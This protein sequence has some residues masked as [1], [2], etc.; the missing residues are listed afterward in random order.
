M[1]RKA[2]PVV[3]AALVVAILAAAM[4]LLHFGAY[5]LYIVHTG[6]MGNTI[7]SRSAV[8]VH[9]GQYHVGQVVSFTL[10]GETVTHRLVS[11]GSDGTITTKGDANRSADPWHP[12]TSN[13]I[14]GVVA[15]PRYLGW[16]L[17][18]LFRTPTGGLSVILLLLC[19]WQ[20]IRLG[21]VFDT[22]E[23]AT[24]SP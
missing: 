13:I 15:A 24:E 20:S 21:D 23:A 12:S 17:V 11:I 8:V 7:P 3:F 5:R 16:V 1:K 9:K 14:G 2:L 10:H 6:S 22:P 19:I 18:Y 4:Y